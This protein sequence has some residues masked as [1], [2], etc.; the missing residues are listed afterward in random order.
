MKNK[1]LLD[2][3]YHIN[4]ENTIII[5]S[6][7]SHYAICSLFMLIALALCYLL[8]TLIGQKIFVDF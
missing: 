4:E 5:Y 1:I 2:E 8:F 7:F 6:H 3:I